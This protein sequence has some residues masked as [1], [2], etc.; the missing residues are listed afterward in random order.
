MFGPD[1]TVSNWSD[2]DPSWPDDEIA[3]YIP[4]TDSG[5]FDY[6]TETIGGESG[7]TRTDNITTSE[8]DNVLVQGIQGDENAIGYFGYAYYVENQDNVKVVPIDNGEGCIEPNE[9]TVNGGEYAPLSRPLFIY[10]RNDALIE[11]EA[12]REFVRYY[13]TE[14]RVVVS[15]VGYVEYPDEIYEENLAALEEVV[16]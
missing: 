15:Q 9:E 16:G 4:G 6:F 5:T 12:V 10:V 3:F 13:M 1:S 7:A 14:G 2:V 11:D 8:D